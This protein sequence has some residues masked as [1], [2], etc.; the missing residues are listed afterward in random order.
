MGAI[1]GYIQIQ[2][3]PAGARVEVRQ[4]RGILA[5]PGRGR[6]AAAAIYST[7]FELGPMSEASIGNVGL[8]PGT[9]A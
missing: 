4:E 5:Q 1:S 8:K 9:M 7:Q 3:D 2:N 6:F